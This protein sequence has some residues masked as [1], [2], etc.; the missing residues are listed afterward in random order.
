MNLHRFLYLLSLLIIVFICSYFINIVI[1][2][3]DVVQ[4]VDF[5]I[6][7]MKTEDR[8]QNINTQLDRL[9]NSQFSTK[10]VEL[11][12]AV[13]GKEL[14]LDI[15]IKEGKL[16]LKGF[17]CDADPAK[18]RQINKNEVGCYLS[19]VKSIDIVAKKNKPGYSVIFED[20]FVIT[21]QFLDTLDK[22]LLTLKNLEFDMFFLGIWGNKGS[23]VIDNVY[24]ILPSFGAHGYLI[25]NQSAY[26]IISQIRHM[27]TVVDVAMF[28][29]GL[30][31]DLTIYR[32]DDVIV[33]QVGLESSIR[34]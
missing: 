5:Y 28:N 10:N 33:D 19:H 23:Q 14:D 26:K 30:S 16:D 21:D 9:R 18:R 8:M 29:K 4:D 25:N 17:N 12:D 27:D 20:D 22:T 31:K 7:T 15:L 1:E 32:I 2:N 24:N 3:F 34:F 11:V 13:V 6:I